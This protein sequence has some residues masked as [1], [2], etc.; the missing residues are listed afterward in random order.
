[1]SYNDPI[2]IQFRIPSKYL[3]YREPIFHVIIIFP[4]LH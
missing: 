2:L 4:E 1:M 3:Q